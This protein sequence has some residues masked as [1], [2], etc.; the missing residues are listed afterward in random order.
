MLR[1][2]RRELSVAWL[3]GAL[4]VVVFFAAADDPTTNIIMVCPESVSAGTTISG[5]AVEF[6]P[7]IYMNSITA[8]GIPLQIQTSNPYSSGKCYFAVPTLETMAGEVVF[9]FAID[10]AGQRGSAVCLVTP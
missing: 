3:V 5:Y 8:S 6:T 7:A 9:I 4:S 1:K 10:S 2:F